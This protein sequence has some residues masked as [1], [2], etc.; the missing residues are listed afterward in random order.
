MSPMDL[1]HHLRVPAPLD[2]VWAVLVDPHRL[3]EVLPGSVVD[4]VAGDSFTG[5][6]KI[7]LASRLLALAGSRRFTTRDERAHRLVVTTSGADRR[8]DAAVE[9]THTLT[10]A[11]AA[12]SAAQTD[13]TVV[14]SLRWTGRPSRLGDGVVADAV[15]HVVEQT[16]ARIAARVAE[17]RGWAPAAGTARRASGAEA[18]GD[19]PVELGEDLGEVEDDAAGTPGARPGPAPSPSPGPSPTPA[20]SP[21]PARTEEYVYRPYDNA[22]EPHLDAVRTFSRVVLRRVAPYA[23]LGAL[24]VLGAVSAVRRVR[25]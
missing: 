19:H 13:V 16:R 25:R 12:G 7:K 5:T 9:A 8:G 6:T 23:G 11:P 18:V 1:T 4:S 24:A 2:E 10:L 20:P 14:S 15:D 22:A 3:A 21:R 17:G